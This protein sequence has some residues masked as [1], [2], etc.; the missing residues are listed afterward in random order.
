MMDL[1]NKANRIA[2]YYFNVIRG[3]TFAGGIAIMIMMLYITADVTGRYLFLNPLPASF[4]ISQ[5]ILIFISF[6]S[7]AYVQARGE[8]LRLGF[9]IRLF[10]IRGQVILNILA[11]LIGIFAFAIIT[12]QAADWG[13]KGLLKAEYEQGYWRFPLGPPRLVLAIGTLITTIQFFFELVRQLWQLFH[14]DGEQ[15]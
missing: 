7:F 3:L 1:R 2:N 6:W 8:H 5:M 12:W 4:E 14:M 13:I 9:F 11:S 10:P 15:Q